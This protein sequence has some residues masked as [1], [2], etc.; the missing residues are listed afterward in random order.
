MCGRFAGSLPPEAIARIFRTRNP[1][2]NL[3]PNWNLAPTQDALVVRRHP[4]TGERH[5][6]LLKWGLVSGVAPNR[7]SGFAVKV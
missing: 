2:P 3:P 6:D 4:E 5:L 7:R 1:I